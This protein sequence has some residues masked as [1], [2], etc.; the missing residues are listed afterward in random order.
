LKAEANRAVE[1]DAS[2]V[3]Q[4][5][6]PELRNLQDIVNDTRIQVWAGQ[7]ASFFEQAMIDASSS[8][9]RPNGT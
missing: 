8:V 4:R 5:P 6:V 9:C 2:L 3:Y 1:R 7:P